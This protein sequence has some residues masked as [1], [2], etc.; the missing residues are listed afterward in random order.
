LFAHILKGSCR[1]QDNNLTI[2]A[3]EFN[4]KHP[5]A[6]TIRRP[7]TMRRTTTTLLPP[8]VQDKDEREPD[9]AYLNIAQRQNIALLLSSKVRPK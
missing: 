7:T 4:T 9:I 5:H 3:N 8:H 2:V 6:T 1:S